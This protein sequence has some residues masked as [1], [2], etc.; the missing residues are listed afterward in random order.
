METP[1][2][3]PRTTRRGAR[4]PA[5]DS[6]AAAATPAIQEVAAQIV[7][8]LPTLVQNAVQQKLFSEVAASPPPQRKALGN[9]TNDFKAR[10]C[11]G[12][13]L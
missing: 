7:E 4:A 6:D 1:V 11:P 12:S 9:L 2:P 8:V 13:F 10:A 3:T 5:A